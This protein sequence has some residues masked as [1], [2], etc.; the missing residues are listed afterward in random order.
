MTSLHERRDEVAP[1]S[2]DF[3]DLCIDFDA[4]ILEPRPWTTAQS[5]WAAELLRSAPPGPVLE[6]CAGAGHIGLLAI[7]LEPRPLVCVD[8]EPVACDYTRSNAERA[9]L[10]D[11]VEVREGSMDAVLEPDERFALVIADPPWVPRDETAHFPEDPVPAIDGG[12]DGLDP[13]R[14]CWALADRH[15]L[16]GGTAVLQV[17]TVAQVECLDAEM[18]GVTR[19]RVGEVRSFERGV[20]V[21]L[22]A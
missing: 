15:L 19:L 9:G 20:L 4:R 8:V 6:L 21:A 12:V 7:H 1:R 5:T 13:A 22:E 18:R 11:L 2:M 14:S 3:G 16:E 17:G 10:G